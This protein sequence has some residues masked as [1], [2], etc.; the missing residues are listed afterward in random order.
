MTWSRFQKISA[1]CLSGVGGAAAY[2]TVEK[3]LKPK[4]VVHN[5]WTTSFEPSACAK[6]DSNWDHRDP[7]ALVKPL[8]GQSEPSP[9]EENKLNEKLEKVK[10][11]AIRHLILIRHGQYNL[12]G[13]KRID[14]TI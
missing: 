6:W 2:W 8:K 1:I 12:D 5:S 7:K 11:T 4:N 10:P 9:A 14:L 13:G 3:Q